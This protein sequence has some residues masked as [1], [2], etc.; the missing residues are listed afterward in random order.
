MIPTRPLEPDDEQWRKL[1][2]ITVDH[3]A[4]VLRDLPAAPAAVL[5]ATAEVLADPML[6]RMPPEHGR[7]L[8]ELLDTLVR[9]AQP[10]LNP[11]SP[12]YLAF[13]PGSGLVSAGL[14]GLVADVLNRYTGLAAPAPGFV[15]LE[16]DLLRWLADLF[17][18]PPTAGGLFTSGGSLAAF[19]ALVAAREDRLPEDFR[20]GTLYVTDQAHASVAKA[21]RL[22]GFPRDAVRVVARDPRH[23]MD[24]DALARLVRAD[25]DGGRVPFCVVATA[26]TTNLGTIDPLPEIAAVCRR[27]ELWLHVDG[28]YGA[29]FQ[30]TARGRERL[31]GIEHADSIVLDPHK[32]FF[33]P[34][35]TGCLLVRD[36]APLQAA[37]AGD[38]AHY[39]QDLAGQE[40]PDFADLGPELTRGFRGIR[41]WLPLHLHGVAAFRA[42]LDEKL[43]LAAW[44]HDELAAEP[45]LTV[46]GRPELTIVGFRC[47]RSDDRDAAT[48]ELLARVDAERRVF[49]SSTRVDGRFVGRIAILNHRTDRERVAEAVEAIRRHARAL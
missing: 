25:R 8:P 14:A 12:G 18:L 16:S 19:S 35:G 31:R 46:L 9:A 33:L 17:G 30:L 29:A 10:G 20:R 11:S 49:L 47:A 40:L 1:A 27:E 32:G 23:R 42:T 5:D 28:A 34:F 22:A 41:L 44:A 45:A 38:E 2:A 21:A 43:D 4:A 7:P 48:A 24:P 26:G 3:L 36:T 37:H 6:R 13:I 39:L 15:A